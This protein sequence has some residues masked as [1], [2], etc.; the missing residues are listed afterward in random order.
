[1][2]RKDLL[3]GQQ[4]PWVHH[5]MFVP[6]APSALIAYFILVWHLRQTCASKTKSRLPLCRHMSY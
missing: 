3:L 4:L 2:C 6:S 5:E 1:M